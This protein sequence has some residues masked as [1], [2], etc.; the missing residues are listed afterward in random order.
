MN[1]NEYIQNNRN[2]K[3]GRLC[4]QVTCQNGLNL[5]VQASFTHYCEPRNDE[6]PYTHVEV[7]YPNRK[8]EALMEY[9]ESPTRPTDTVYAFVPVALVEQVIL[10]NGGLANA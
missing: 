1:I 2:G 8:V 4:K 10:E 6:G 3:Y 9:A 5:S 7:G